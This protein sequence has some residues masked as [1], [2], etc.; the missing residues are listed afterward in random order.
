MNGQRGFFHFRCPPFHVTIEN[1]S[2]ELER[3]RVMNRT[4]GHTIF[5]QQGHFFSSSLQDQPTTDFAK[6]QYMRI[7]VK[8]LSKKSVGNV[9]MNHQRLPSFLKY[10]SVL[11]AL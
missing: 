11:V 10:G 5:I 9:I 8:K 7:T 4:Y 2:Y 3:A 6:V 1:S